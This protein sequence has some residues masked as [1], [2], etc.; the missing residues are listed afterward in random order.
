MYV[1]CVLGVRLQAK[2]DPKSVVS[3][4]CCMAELCCCLLC[5]GAV[6]HT[7]SLMVCLQLL[8]VGHAHAKVNICLRCPSRLLL[9]I[10]FSRYLHG[11]AAGHSS[12]HLV[13]LHVNNI[14][15]VSFANNEIVQ[16]LLKNVSRNLGQCSKAELGNK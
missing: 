1:R 12:C 15:K 8:G 13:F 10:V 14:F 4:A 16:R 5:K 2:P 7:T 3:L 11:H 9:G 6:T